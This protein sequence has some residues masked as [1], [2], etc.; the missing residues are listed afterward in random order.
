[1]PDSSPKKK[2]MRM[3]TLASARPPRL[4]EPSAV[5]AAERGLS[6]SASAGVSHSERLGSNR[7][8]RVRSSMPMPSSSTTIRAR[9]SSTEE[10]S[11]MVSGSTSRMACLMQFSSSG[12]RMNGG[13]CRSSEAGSRSAA[14]LRRPSPYRACMRLM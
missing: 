5:T 8:A 10:E 3:S 4:M 6:A 12:C 2:W 14:S 11:L 1:M 13:T 9:S 7:C